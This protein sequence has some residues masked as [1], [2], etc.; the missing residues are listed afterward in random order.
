MQCTIIAQKNIF[1]QFYGENYEIQKNLGRYP[2]EPRSE[3]KEKTLQLQSQR[4]L[5]LGL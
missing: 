3:S 5:S 4:P 1:E 2:T